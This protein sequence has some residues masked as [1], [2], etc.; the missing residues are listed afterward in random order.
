MLFNG[1]YGAATLLRARAAYQAMQ[2]DRP[3]FGAVRE[4]QD[5]PDVVERAY[6]ADDLA[7]L[8]D[9]FAAIGEPPPALLEGKVMGAAAE[10]LLAESALASAEGAAAAI[11]AGTLT[12]DDPAVQLVAAIADDAEAFAEAMGEIAA[13]ERALAQRLGRARFAAYGNAV[14]PDATFS[15]R[16]TDGVV[17]GYEY[18]GTL[19][20]PMTTLHGLY[21]RYYAFCEAAGMEPCDWDLPARWLDE[22]GEV[23]RGTPVNF[24]STS[25]TIGGNSGSPVLNR[26]LELVG[27]NFDR[28]IEGLARD[29]IYLPDR[30]R[31]VMVDVRVVLEAL[32]E[33]YDMDDLA[34]ELTEGTLR[35]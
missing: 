8:R 29:F 3:E 28:T 16:F 32:T 5:R 1:G 11:E 6:L 2:S 9:Y 10:R 7:L 25:D 26:D 17:R 13:E 22:A 19:A 12:M 18:N 21:D 24:V 4:I 30:G 15:L 35:E 34:A 23:D 20:P 27:L 33:V 14:P 31:N